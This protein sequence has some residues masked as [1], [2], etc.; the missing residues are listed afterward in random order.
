MS[1]KIVISLGKELIDSIWITFVQ[2]IPLRL[3]LNM[4][5]FCKNIKWQN[6][7]SQ[8]NSRLRTSDRRGARC[9]STSPT[10][11]TAPVWTSV[12]GG[13]NLIIIHR[14]TTIV[15]TYYCRC[16]PDSP[17]RETCTGPSVQVLELGDGIW[18]DTAHEDNPFSDHFKV[19]IHSCSNDDFSG[20]ADHFLTI[21][22]YM[23]CVHS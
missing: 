8:P 22:S 6:N 17:D 20:E 2:F 4:R 12:R 14:L 21:K 15:V 11:A 23:V 18:S 3:I 19:F 13:D 10:L 16:A 7:H 1:Q 9:W 5:N